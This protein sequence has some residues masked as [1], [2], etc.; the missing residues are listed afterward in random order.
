M[1]ERLPNNPEL[2]NTDALWSHSEFFHSGVPMEHVSRR[3]SE[4][5]D[6]I[7]G[8]DHCRWVVK[9]DRTQC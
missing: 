3:D 5:A 9:V 6:Y 4:L 8:G 2:T 7:H 1:A